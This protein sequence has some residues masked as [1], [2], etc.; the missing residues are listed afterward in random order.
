MKTEICV[1]G[2]GGGGKLAE[3]LGNSCG[4][5][6]GYGYGILNMERGRG[7]S[8]DSEVTESGYAST[9]I[10]SGKPRLF[11]INQEKI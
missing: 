3:M 5:A 8:C 9:I 10:Q 7:W 1:M 2:G 11:L 4:E 6:K